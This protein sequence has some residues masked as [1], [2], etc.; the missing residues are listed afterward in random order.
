MPTWLKDWKTTEIIWTIGYPIW[1]FKLLLREGGVKV[2]RNS[3][4]RKIEKTICL[5]NLFYRL[6]IWPCPH[7]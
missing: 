1:H 2:L 6:F 4:L 5:K 7:F 3:W